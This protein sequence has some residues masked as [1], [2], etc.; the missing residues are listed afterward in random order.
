M[1][2]TVF[3][4]PSHENGELFASKGNVTLALNYAPCHE[5][6]WG[7]GSIAPRIPNLGIL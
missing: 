7:S 5:D 4:L 2:I 3:Q 1:D 6:V